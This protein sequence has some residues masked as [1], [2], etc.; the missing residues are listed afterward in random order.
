MTAAL[1]NQSAEHG[2]YTFD[3][4]SDYATRLGNHRSVDR[5]PNGRLVCDFF[6]ELLCYFHTL[7]TRLEKYGVDCARTTNDQ[8]IIMNNIIKE[9]YAHKYATNNRLALYL[10]SKVSLR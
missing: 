1:F 9:Y 4:R 10:A 3:S 7:E 2:V 6:N 8:Y 5:G